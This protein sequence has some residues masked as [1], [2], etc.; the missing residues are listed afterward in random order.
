MSAPSVKEVLT[1][2][3]QIDEAEKERAA[4]ALR[5][6]ELTA[7]LEQLIGVGPEPEMTAKVPISIDVAPPRAKRM[8]LIQPEEL[9]P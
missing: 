4:A 2:A 7:K 6:A 8:P 9:T 5:K 3:R 1:L